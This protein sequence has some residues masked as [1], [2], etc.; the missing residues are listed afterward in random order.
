MIYSAL[1]AGVVRRAAS[2]GTSSVPNTRASF[3]FP[4]LC[5]TFLLFLY[6]HFCDIF[7]LH[8][9]LHFLPSV[10]LF[11]SFFIGISVTPHPYRSS[12]LL[13]T[14]AAAPFFKASYTDAPTKDPLPGAA[15]SNRGAFQTSLFKKYR[16]IPTFSFDLLY[17]S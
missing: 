16:P 8:F 1:L 14:A 17:T 15:C 12:P 7:P 10:T 5:H 6:R 9:T 2:A 3:T 13:T 11:S 4:T